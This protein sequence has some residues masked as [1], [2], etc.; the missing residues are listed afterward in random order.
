MTNTFHSDNFFGNSDPESLADQY[1]SPLYVY[2]EII[3]RERCRDI[4][5]LAGNA[6]TEASYSVKANSNPELL[7]IIRQEGL[8]ADAM[9]PGE[10]FMDDMAGWDAENI[11]YISNNNGPDE[12]LNAISHGC[13]VSVD[14]LSQLDMFGSIC[15]GGRVMARI[16]PGI[17][18][19]HSDKVVTG[20]AKTKFGIA[21]SALPEL[22]DI[23]QTHE[24][25]LAGLNQHIG[26]LFLEPTPYLEAA[27][28]LLAF[29]TSLPASIFSNLE[30]LD[31]GGGFG[32]SYHKGGNGLNLEETAEGL[33]KILAEWRADTGYQGRFLIEPGRYIVAQCGRL[34][35]QVT[36]TKTNGGVNYVGTDIGFNILMRPVLYD[37]W[38]E[39][40]SRGAIGE[41]ILQTITGN[42]CESGDILAK[43]RLL[44]PLKPGNLVIVHDT[45]AYGF[46]MAS[47]YNER[48]LPAEILVCENGL[49]K[50]IRRRQ[51]LADLASCLPVEGKNSD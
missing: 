2:N 28:T 43:D 48:L 42:I 19:G 32:I 41:P 40:E 12:L 49:A 39:V 20:G 18:A 24:L 22:L 34:I 7:R 30:I 31:F 13:L 9:S 33:G 51:T 27:S 15:R 44:P 1:G 35:G 38:H 3:L 4:M 23:L 47:N 14:S 11:F 29:A 37:A 50:L 8:H 6:G 10:L 25:R 16:N 36:S 26:S 46:S 45:G 5:R 17:G 21:M